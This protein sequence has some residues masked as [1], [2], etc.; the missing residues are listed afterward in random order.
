M[1]IEQAGPTEDDLTPDAT[2]QFTNYELGDYSFLGNIMAQWLTQFLEYRDGHPFAGVPGMYLQGEDTDDISLEEANKAFLI[3]VEKVIYALKDENPHDD[4]DDFDEWVVHERL[5][6][7]KVEE[8]IK[9]FPKIWP[10]LWI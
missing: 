10:S 9:L 4:I 8:G 3:D 5:H 7:L 2:V 6:Q 1:R